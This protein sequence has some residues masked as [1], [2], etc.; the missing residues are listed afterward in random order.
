VD[1]LSPFN[2]RNRVIQIDPGIDQLVGGTTSVSYAFINRLFAKVRGSSNPRDEIL[3][4]TLSQSWYSNAQAG[5]IDPNYPSATI[6]SYSPIN[7]LVSSSPIQDVDGR[8]Q[9]YIDPI[10]RAVQSYSAAAY[11]RPHNG[12]RF[13]IKAGWS[14]RPF[15]LLDPNFNNSNNS[16]HFLNAGT[17]VRLFQG[18]IEGTY[19]FNYDLKNS[20]FLQQRIRGYYGSQCCGLAVEYQMMNV[21][22]FALS[23]V[24]RDRRLAVTF[25]LAG[26]GSF[27][28]PLGGF[29]R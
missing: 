25:N 19:E 4:V 26:L 15:R 11:L 22:Q 3:S 1:Y 12:E 5:A 9:V 2:E 10:T 8:F 17:T 24:S 18:R 6:N 13:E 27:A 16:S 29:A 21:S 28:A 20:G 23:G 7:F 14:R